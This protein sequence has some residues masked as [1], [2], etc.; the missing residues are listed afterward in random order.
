MVFKANVSHKGITNKYEIDNEDLVG[1]LI[2]DKIQGQQISQDLDGYELEL[3][4]TSD[5]AGFPGLKD[6]KGP[7]L[8][9]LLL[10][11]GLAMR[12]TREGVRI[13]KTVRG[14]EVSLDTVQ[15][16][17]QVIK[18]GKTKAEELFKKKQEASEEK[19]E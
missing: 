7:N 8:K 15:L 19:A 10:K 1:I 18:E 12:D 14:N 11:R 13:R 3:R 2:G 5:K 6:Q 17:L 16:N 4:G 9:K